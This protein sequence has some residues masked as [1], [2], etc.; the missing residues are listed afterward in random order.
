LTSGGFIASIGAWIQKFIHF[1]N[2]ALSPQQHWAKNNPYAHNFNNLCP[3]LY[4]LL[5]DAVHAE[6][7][8]GWK[9]WRASTL[10]VSKE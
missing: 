7:G 4:K 10:R 5:T 6:S 3:K 8:F 1:M 9:F 2:G